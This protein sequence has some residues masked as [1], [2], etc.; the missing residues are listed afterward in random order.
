MN[1][2]ALQETDHYFKAG[3]HDGAMGCAAQTPRE[4]YERG[5]DAYQTDCY[6][7]GAIDGAE[8]DTFRYNGVNHG[9]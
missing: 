9:S 7:Q 8:G 3:W 1:H 5:M 4:C 6:L 2:M